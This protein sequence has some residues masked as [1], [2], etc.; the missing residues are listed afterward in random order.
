MWKT[1]L[2]NRVFFILKAESIN[3]DIKFG[4]F[5][6]MIAKLIKHL[7]REVVGTQGHK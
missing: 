6:N 4:S 3:M 1:Y 2:L 5:F 7:P